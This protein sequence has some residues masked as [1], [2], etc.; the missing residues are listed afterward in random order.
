MHNHNPPEISSHTINLIGLAPGEGRYV[1]VDIIDTMLQQN[2]E[3]H[4]Y[5]F[6][7]NKTAYLYEWYFS[8]SDEPYHQDHIIKVSLCQDEALTQC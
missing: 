3:K 2:A 1:K 7:T 5:Y 4:G 6:C 8:Q